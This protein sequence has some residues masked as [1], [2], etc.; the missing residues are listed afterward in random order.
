M[1][2]SNGLSAIVRERVSPIIANVSDTCECVLRLARMGCMRNF[3]TLYVLSG[4]KVTNRI[5][6]HLL[7]LVLDVYNIHSTILYIH[8]IIRFGE[9]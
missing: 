1:R 9:H 7:W 3:T 5:V 8:I 2:N 6:G 4:N